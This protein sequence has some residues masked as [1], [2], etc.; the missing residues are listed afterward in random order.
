MSDCA[1]ACVIL[2]WPLLPTTQP[3]PVA[4]HLAGA[5]MRGKKHEHHLHVSAQQR[6]EEE[7]SR[8]SAHA[9]AEP[10]TKRGPPWTPQQERQGAQPP[11]RSDLRLGAWRLRGP[12][13]PVLSH[14]WS[15]GELVHEQ[16]GSG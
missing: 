16:P 4:T 11:L 12:S 13:I 2:I 6:P 7:S 8:L 1:H 15:N 9:S 5:G 3:D 14:G 10:S